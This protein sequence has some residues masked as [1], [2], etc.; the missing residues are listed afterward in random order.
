MSIKDQE[1][2]PYWYEGKPCPR[3]NQV[4]IDCECTLKEVVAFITSKRNK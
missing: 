3:C 4:I 2:N 1:A